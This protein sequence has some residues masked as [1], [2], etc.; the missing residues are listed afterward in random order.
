[1]RAELPNPGGKLRP[2]MLLRVRVELPVRQALVLP[3][4]AVQQEGGNSSVFRVGKDQKAEQVPVELGSRREGKV[5]VLSGLRAGD[6][7]VV[8]GIV[9]LRAGTPVVEAGAKGPDAAAGSDAGG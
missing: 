2:G 6:R 1:M 7:V 3:E 5:E 9:K 8:D 4:L